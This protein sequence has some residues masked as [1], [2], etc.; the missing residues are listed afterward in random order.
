MAKRID[1][2]GIIGWHDQA[3]PEYLGGEL[4]AA[5]GEE[6]EVHF[7]SPGGLV[8]A[9]LKMYNQLRDYPGKTTAVLAGYAM[10]MASYI[11]QACNVVMAKD[12]A[13]YMI[14]NARGWTGGDH[15]EVLKY[16]NY[17]KGLS[18]ISAREFVKQTTRRGKGKSLEDVTAMMDTETFLFGEEMVAQGFVDGILDTGD[19]SD[20]ETALATAQ[21]TFNEAMALMSSDPGKV[22]ADLQLA[23]Q[24]FGD[25]PATQSFSP[26]AATAAGTKKEE[27]TTMSLNALLA[28]NPQAKAEYDAAITAAEAR[29]KV[30]GTEE[31]QATAKA[32]GNFLSNKEYPVQVGEMALKVLTGEQSKANLDMVV[33]MADMMKEQQKGTQAA[34]GTTATGETLGQGGGEAPVANATDVSSPIDLAAAI[35]QFKG[36]E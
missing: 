11:P 12:N 6:V 27:G 4:R 1:I 24:L 7:N 32:V 9:G 29:G 33:S 10:S 23:M 17:L 5:N 14:H 8:G 35:A 19:D 18:G 26:P 30:A 22:K 2:E 31:M 13:V 34:A 15:N 28:A 21:A 20:K 25:V 16:G 3:T 36:G